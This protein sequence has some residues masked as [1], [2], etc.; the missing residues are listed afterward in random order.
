MLSNTKLLGLAAC[1][2]TVLAHGGVTSMSIGST[3]YQGWQPYLPAAG[4]VTAERPYSSY[5]PILNPTD[6]TMS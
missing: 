3:T 5:N 4:Q 6:P 1:I 2:S